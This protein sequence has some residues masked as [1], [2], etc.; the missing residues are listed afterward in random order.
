ML[1]SRPNPAFRATWQDVCFGSKADMCSAKQHVRFSPNSD[2]N[3]VFRHVHFGA[4]HSN[5]S[6]VIEMSPEDGARPS[7]LAVLRLMVSS[8]LADCTTGKSAGFSPLRILPV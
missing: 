2:I 4:S 7:D 5:T 3:C 8:N 1:N 6:S